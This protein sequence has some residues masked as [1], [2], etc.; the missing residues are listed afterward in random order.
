MVKT[1]N[2]DGG[3]EWYI[4]CRN[5]TQWGWQAKYSFDTDSLLQGMEKSLKT[6]VEK[7]PDCRRLTFCIPFDLPDAVEAG[8][9]ESA[10]QRFEDR[11]KSWSNRIPGADRVRIE[12]WPEGDLLQRLV[13]HPGQRGITRFFWDKE[14]F[15]PE[16]C[17][18]RMAITHEVAGRRYT[19]ELHINLPV[20]FA[21][22]GL[23]MSEAYWH[24]FR[25]ARNRVLRAAD[26][27]Q[28]SRYTG[29]GVTNQL[30]QLKRSLPGGSTLPRKR[31]RYRNGWINPN[32]LVL[33]VAAWN[34]SI[35]PIRQD[36]HKDKGY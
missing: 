33:Q 30:R 10:R 24:R 35:T 19:P 8:K 31:L 6:V 25:D 7:R 34:S 12:L 13:R 23:A 3:L 2:P 14:I 20:S 32:C 9:R 18:H 22:E 17:A 15:S 5:G 16:W 27:I 4:T 36:R 1:G 29:L 26:R 21:L 11:K 28:M